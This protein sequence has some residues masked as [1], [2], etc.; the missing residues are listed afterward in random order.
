[1]KRYPETEKILRLV[2]VFANN[3]GSGESTNSYNRLAE[4]VEELVQ[5]LHLLRQERDF[6]KA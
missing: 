5:E 4:A 3:Y 6:H 1:M 2:Y